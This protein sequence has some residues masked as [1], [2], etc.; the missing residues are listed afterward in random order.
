MC[1][2]K[3]DLT[4]DTFY[5]PSNRMS[6]GLRAGFPELGQNSTA[7]SEGSEN[8]MRNRKVYPHY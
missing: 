4:M 1:G 5:D 7:A 8:C 3:K 6:F 2:C